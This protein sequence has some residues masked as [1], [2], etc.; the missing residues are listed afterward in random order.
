MVRRPLDALKAWLSEWISSHGASRTFVVNE[1][2]VLNTRVGGRIQTTHVSFD[3][4]ID[5]LPIL[6]ERI[7]GSTL[8]SS[9]EWLDY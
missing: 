9:M 5:R 4:N 1:E 8:V 6:L 3:S 7:S 2:T